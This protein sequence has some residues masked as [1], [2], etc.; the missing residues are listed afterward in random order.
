MQTATAAPAVPGATGSQPI[1]PTVANQTER[2]ARFRSL[3]SRSSGP[4]EERWWEPA[5]GGRSFGKVAHPILGT[6]GKSERNPLSLQ[7]KGSPGA[8][9]E[10]CGRARSP[11]DPRP[12]PTP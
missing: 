11:S 10:G 12:E 8:V 2:E 3:G 1:G 7:F 6:V 4:S 5:W 9:D